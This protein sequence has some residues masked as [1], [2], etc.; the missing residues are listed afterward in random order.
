M[1]NIHTQS[2]L[3]MC[4]VYIRSKIN[5]SSSV[6]IKLTSAHLYDYRSYLFLKVDICFCIEQ[7]THNPHIVLASGKLECSLSM[8]H[9]GIGVNLLHIAVVKIQFIIVLR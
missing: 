5:D 2:K 9:T 4:S 7:S 8:L 3:H 6:K 1:P